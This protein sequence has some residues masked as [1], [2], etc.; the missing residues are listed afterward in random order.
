MKIQNHNINNR[1]QLF[2]NFAFLLPFLLLC[3]FVLNYCNTRVKFTIEGFTIYALLYL[4]LIRIA[5]IT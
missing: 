5:K 3:I 2:A 4:I 1:L